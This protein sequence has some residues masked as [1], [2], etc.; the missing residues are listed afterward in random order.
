MGKLSDWVKANSKDGADITEFE[1]LAMDYSIEGIDSKE[2]AVDFMK[3]NPAFNSG[4]DYYTSE[5]V[6]NHDLKFQK[7]KLPAMLETERQKIK[8][9]LNPPETE[10]EKKLR[11]M[12]KT[13]TEMKQKEIRLETE[14]TLRSKAKELGYPEDKAERFAVYGENAITM[15]EDEAKYLGE[16]VNGMLE[17]EIKK[18]FGS[19]VPPQR[20]GQTPGKQ[21][22]RADYDNLSPS[23]QSTYVTDGGSVVDN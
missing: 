3:K 2:K 9:E 10:A 5:A 23:E 22:T 4:L 7:E 14:K 15:L 13:L 8:D 12:E 6:K 20:S 16:T 11:D 17:G 1:K 21:M 19:N 18:R